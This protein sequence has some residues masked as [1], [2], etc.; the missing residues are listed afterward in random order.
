[1]INRTGDSTGATLAEALIAPRVSAPAKRLVKDKVP[2]VAT[3][4]VAATA[5]TPPTSCAP[6]RPAKYKPSAEEIAELKKKNSKEQKIL[7][8]TQKK[9]RRTAKSLLNA[10][11]ASAK[12]GP[13]PELPSVQH[14]FATD[15]G[16]DYKTHRE[17][18]IKFDAYN[19]LKLQIETLKI[20][21]EDSLPVIDESK[22]IR[23]DKHH[24]DYIKN[25]RIAHSLKYATDDTT[26][27]FDS[28]GAV[29]KNP[30]FYFDETTEDKQTISDL[31]DYF[32]DDEKNY[33]ASLE[34][35]HAR[36]SKAPACFSAIF[37][38]LAGEG[39]EKPTK[40]CFLALS[41][42]EEVA[43][44]PAVQALLI[45]LEIATIHYSR[46][47]PDCKFY[48]LPFSSKAFRNYMTELH[49]ESF[50]A[51]HP[52]QERE[53]AEA[54]FLNALGK[55]YQT[56][57]TQFQVTSVVNC[58]F[59][60]LRKNAAAEETAASSVIPKITDPQKSFHKASELP[61][62]K[63]N[64]VTWY[65]CD[66]CQSKKVVALSM[67]LTAQ[68]TPRLTAIEETKD[69][70]RPLYSP[71]RGSAHFL[72]FFKHAIAAKKAPISAA[73]AGRED[74]AAVVAEDKPT[75]VTAIVVK[76]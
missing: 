15:S 43:K 58:G 25:L 60:P 28:L 18:V 9:E 22:L 17:T 6:K 2:V 36:A 38:Q 4:T 63:Y 26:S 3:A 40:C 54:A 33:N 5:A 76:A 66:L 50:S 27:P 48:L 12:S 55:V 53:C 46:I 65:C 16:F 29:S 75:V 44:K 72:S 35:Q 39:D 51:A 67:L 62:A 10:S 31:L 56:Y 11:L 24:P 73:L 52:I 68:S 20:S 69:V 34:F 70:S 14:L 23:S 45:Q 74:A 71:I 59:Y 8:E 41:S 47:N 49:Q 19:T 32:W 21:S 64:V 7:R 57:G 30:K 1:M 61:S 13:P 37:G 42:S